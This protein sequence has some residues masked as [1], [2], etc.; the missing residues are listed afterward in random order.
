MGARNTLRT[1][2]TVVIS[3][4]LLAS[5]ALAAPPTP[6]PSLGWAPTFET[7]TGEIE[8]LPGLCQPGGISFEFRSTGVAVGPY[9]GTYVETGRVTLGPP[10]VAGPF[11]SVVVGLEAE[12]RI[13]A[14]FD[15]SPVTITGN[16]RLAFPGTGHCSD[17]PD[18]GPMSTRIAIVSASYE[19]RIKTDRGVYFDRGSSFVAVSE[20]YDPAD[21]TQRQ[22][23]FSEAFFSQLG[24][25]AAK[26]GK[27]C[28]DERHEHIRSGECRMD[29]N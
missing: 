10:T 5:Q 14:V 9:P 18:V 17:A 4:G 7:L 19:A 22:S 24:P 15:G 20:F 23:L 8:H 27:G 25:E 21:P 6:P 13:D 29:M 1:V 3:F 26:P 16:K 12:F 11:N 28:G 2:T